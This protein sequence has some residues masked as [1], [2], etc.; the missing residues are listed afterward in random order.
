VDFSSLMGSLEHVSGWTPLA[1]FAWGLASVAL[2]PCH[3]TSVP[4]L[5]TFLG[6]MEGQR[7]SSRRLAVLVTLGI[8]LSL[9]VVAAVTFAL[10]RILGDL[11]G[12]GPWLMVALLLLGGLNLMGAFELPSIGRLDP[13]RARP[14]SKS[15]LVSGAILGTSLGPC[16]FSFFAPVL[17]LFGTAHFTALALASVAAFALGH[18]GVTFVLGFAGA[19]LGAR[20]SRGARWAKALKFAVGALSVGFALSLIVTTPPVVFGGP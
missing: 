1:A 8:S 6:R 14:G 2:S 4:L 16:T 20:L 17:A 15:A 18:L 5:V 3:L 11:W 19:E 12:V 9:L 7:L 13:K 10:G